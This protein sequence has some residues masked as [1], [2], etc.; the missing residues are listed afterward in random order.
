MMRFFD[1]S[2]PRGKANK[3]IQT[4]PSRE[5]KETQELVEKPHH[6]SKKKIKIEKKP[7]SKVA[8]NHCQRRW[9][10]SLE[11]LCAIN[12][13]EQCLHV[14]PGCLDLHLLPPWEPGK[15]LVWGNW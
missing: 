13:D 9:R 15:D 2:L 6:I 7:Q 3:E 1:L 4:A 14:S 8:N 5:I 10:R 12:P 11:V